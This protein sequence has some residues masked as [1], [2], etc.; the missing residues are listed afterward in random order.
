MDE[1][2][3]IPPV[4]SHDQKPVTV[5]KNSNLRR[6][7]E[8]L[9]FSEDLFRSTFEWASMGMALG[10]CDGTFARTN[11]AFDRMMG[12]EPG[13]LIG[14]HRSAVTPP[15]DVA[16]NEERYRQ[17]LE[18]GLPSLTYEKR[19]VRKDG[20]VIWVDVN[21][22]FVR[23]ADGNARFSIIMARDITQH[24]EME[25]VLRESEEKY[26]SLLEH[27]YDAIMIADFDGNLLEL[28][29]K[30]E[31]L[32]S[33]TKEELIGT[34]ISKIHP[35]EELGRILCAFREMV[36]GKTHSLFDTRL[37]R[38][39]GKT[40]PVDI[41]G[42]AIG[43]GGR[44]VAQAIC[45]DITDRK[46]IEKQLKDDHEHL[47][48][49]VEERTNEL[50]KSEKEFRDIFDN[51]VEGIYQTTPEG[52]FLRVNPALAHMYGYG[53]P[54]NLVQ[55]ITNIGTEI[56]T[57]PERRKDF[58]N[59]IEKDGF[60]HDFEIQVRRKDG[61]IGYVSLNARAIKDENGK[62]VYFE[63]TAQDIS[64]NKLAQEQL[65]LQRDL[66]LKLCQIE[67]LEEGMAFIL[68]TAIAVSG[69][70]CGAISLKNDETGEF[71]LISSIN[72]TN[73]FRERV[74][75]I[76]VGSFTWS[77]V[78]EKKSFHFRPDRNKTPTALQEGFQFVS[79]MPMLRGD[80][81]VG[82]LATA[83]R[84][85]TDISERVRISLEFL[86]AESG[87]I[88]ARIQARERLEAEIFI[89]KEAEDA[90]EIERQSLEE[91]NTA[92]K[93][94]LKHREEDRK[95]LEER[96]L[97]NVQQLVM[98]HVQKLKTSVLDPVQQTNVAL[99]ESNLS[100]LITPFLRTVQA[101]NFT[102]RQMEVVILIREGKTTK[103][104]TR[105]LRMNERAVDIQ[106]YLIRKKLG[107][108]K[109]KTNLQTYLK[110]LS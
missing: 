96:L 58:I 77:H 69:M 86:A 10:V 45:R 21:V 34:N 8:E 108:N 99:V 75:H 63:G 19:Y 7:A 78:V 43:Y 50:K 98:P 36:E 1:N 92:L 106:R 27:A 4:S 53:A 16:E 11:A 70:E 88:I 20:R 35:E 65:L 33:Y 29:K 9:I 67:S 93:V 48:R 28:N 42:G 14:V 60:V 30:A 41:S 73:E 18:T 56:Y 105:I 3:K 83:S 90:L 54:D 91:A 13:E 100:E 23:D 17:F 62:T 46:K 6:Q 64:E 94:L 85:L 101:F 66:A 26:R 80:Q 47:E 59:V 24:K 38:K 37:L 32:L 87:N 103:E 15:E 25:E 84:V 72:F 74:Q 107:L 76:P 104:I 102:P 5:Q 57:D 31:E 109:K 40:I 12:Y 82:F 89:R 22:S 2:Q 79:V 95:E 52:R 71:D 110:S 39:D 81:V 55:S 44:Q 61:F 68:Q 49:L 97:T 51:A